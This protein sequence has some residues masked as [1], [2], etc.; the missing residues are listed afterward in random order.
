MYPLYHRFANLSIRKFAN[1]RTITLRNSY[2]LLHFCVYFQLF[3][4]SAFL[5]AIA[6][7]KRPNHDGGALCVCALL[8][9]M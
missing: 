9:R 1:Y 5:P 4:L 8:R 7:K 2:D 6:N 3:L